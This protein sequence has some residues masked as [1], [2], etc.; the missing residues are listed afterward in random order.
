MHTAE[1]PASTLS[2]LAKDNEDEH[3]KLISKWLREALYLATSFPIAVILFSLTIFG[4]GSNLFLPLAVVVFLGLL[5]LMENVAT[6]EVNRTNKILGT[7]FRVVR[8]W[9]ST[10][11]FSWE[12]AKQ[13]ITSL[14]SWMAIGYVFAGFGWSVFSFITLTIGV[15]G[16]FVFLVGLG[17]I[18]LAGI[19]RSFEVID[20]GD[21]FSG[22]IEFIDSNTLR[23]ELGDVIDRGVI[24][25]SFDSYPTLLIA[26]V[27]V[28]FS[29]WLIPRNAR[30]Q[31][32][33]VE[34]LLSGVLLPQLES[35]LKRIA[36]QGKVSERDVREAMET[37]AARE[38]LADLSRRE[39]EIITLMAQGKS[40]AGI[41]K[42]LYITEG[43]VEKHISSI[44]SKL[45]LPLEEDSHRRVLAVLKFLGLEQ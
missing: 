25:W 1:T 45:N 42:E 16:L 7:D 33:I 29:L 12:G 28:I 24:F 3:M 5:T 10:P 34:G 39:R 23:L 38:N 44:L 13:R 9:F 2:V 14:R 36:K 8:N 30:A 40:N 4:L 32:Q 18:G 43:S 41:A 27:A 19:S 11:F 6:F 22:S 26:A 17:I 37:D 20:N 31:A 15:A 35:W 21:L